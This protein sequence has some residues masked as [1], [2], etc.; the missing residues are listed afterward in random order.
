MSEEPLKDSKPIV[1]R[2]EKGQL[3]KGSVLNP[4]GYRKGKRNYNTL[5]EEATAEMKSKGKL[6]NANEVDK[7]AIKMAVTE[8]L[9]HKSFPFYKDTQ[10]RRYGKAPESIDLTTNGESINNPNQEAIDVLADELIKRLKDGNN[11][12]A[13]KTES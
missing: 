12:G 6:L 13:G 2:N 8:M 9:T 11:K 7:L 10:D 5:Y 1:K 3:E 4:N